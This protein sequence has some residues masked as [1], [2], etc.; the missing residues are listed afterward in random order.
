MPLCRHCNERQAYQS[1]GLCSRCY[2]RGDIRIQYPPHYPSNKRQQAATSD[3]MTMAEIEAVIAEQLPTM[4]GFDQQ[5]DAKDRAQD[6]KR[7]G[8]RR[9]K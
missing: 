6:R 7:T 8:I 3:K 9:M 5:E 4:P 1:R 2:N